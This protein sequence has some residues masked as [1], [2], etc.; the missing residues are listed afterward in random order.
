M[1]ELLWVK[2][3]HKSFYTPAGELKV[4]KGVDAVFYEG[5]IVSIVGVSGSGK[6]TFLHIVG[7]LDRPTNGSIEYRLGDT[8]WCNPFLL[9]DFQLALFRNREIGFIFQFHYLMPEFTA[10]ENVLMP[11]LIS[12]QKQRNVTVEICKQRAEKLLDK[13]GIYSRKDH[14][15]GE[16]SGGEQQRVAVARALIMNP[17]IVL[18]DEPTG[19]LDAI[20]GEELF[21]LIMDLNHETGITFIIVTHNTNLSSKCHRVLRMIDGRLTEI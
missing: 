13:L 17:K 1:K 2:G 20:T 9:S 19:N 14:K 10:I 8:E 16:L 3:L 15:P 4:L 6:S 21:K 18:A 12:L 7:T 11:A 5:E